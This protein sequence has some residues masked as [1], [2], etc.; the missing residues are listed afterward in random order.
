[1][2]P[3]H[4][5]EPPSSNAASP[6][7]R[8]AYLRPQYVDQFQCIGP[9][10]EDT[11][12]QG[13]SVPIDRATYEKYAAI[14]S[15]K[16]HLGTVI[17]PNPEGAKRS[18]FARIRTTSTSACF[19]LDEERLCTIQRQHGPSLL[20]NTCA[21]YPRSITTHA[22]V[23]ERSLSLSCPEAA[24][25]TLLHD[26]LL[27]SS[28]SL[29]ASDAPWQETGP[30]RYAAIFQ[31]IARFQ[32]AERGQESPD[33]IAY[34][35]V[36]ATREFA[37]LL[38]TDRSYPLWQRLLLLGTV[39]RQL[40][41]LS[42][43]SSEAAYATENPAV[44]AQLLADSATVVSQNKLRA[45]MDEVSL[46]PAEQL[47]LILDLLRLRIAQ[48]P[49]APR[50]LECLKDFETGLGTAT[51]TSEAEIIAAFTDAYR[52]Y[53]RPLLERHPHLL[54]N[55][56][57]N[58]VFRN[59][60]PFGKPSNQSDQAAGEDTTD[61]GNEHML[62]CAQLALLQTVLVGMAAHHREAFDT[63][64]VVKLVQSLAKTVEHSKPFLRQISTYVA[65]RNLNNLR[66]I[67]LLL[68]PND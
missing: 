51:A 47:P 15:M 42:Q 56:L 21:T 24:R 13:W 11:C 34:D 31:E 33:L 65:E 16:P 59:N 25:L 64:H 6:S 67:A 12:C 52:R 37:L 20:S 55:Y 30:E 54:E 27:G 36:L 3:N 46:Q 5:Y 40:Q 39:A 32:E 9:A 41:T 17:V 29:L 60:Y 62:L 19:F 38:L 4:A 35:P 23:E 18:D 49:I 57:A 44:V 26:N 28:A 10:C 45:V 61:A 22:G 66:G 58:Y 68:K 43:G 2:H 7:P 8:R 14:E 63:T 1:M 48:P 53:V 50:F